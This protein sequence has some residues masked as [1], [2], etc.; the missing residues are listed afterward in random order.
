MKNTIS[1]LLKLLGCVLCATFS[2]T[3][4]ANHR[5]GDFPL[6]EITTGGDFNKDGNIDLAVNLSGFDNFAVLMGDGLGNFTL[7]RHVQLDTLSKQV[8]S[9]DVNGDG[10]IDVVGV[11]QWG[12]NIKV[13]LG[14]GL[15]G[16]QLSN[17]MNG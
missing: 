11:M 14:D 9:G 3:A 12:Y 4:F 10:N 15:G 16:F 8:A 13:Y 17:T 1:N 6:P 7:K 2:S 5:S